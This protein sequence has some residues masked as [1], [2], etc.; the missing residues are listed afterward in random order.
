MVTADPN[1]TL[2]NLIKDQWEIF[3]DFSKGFIIA[4][5]GTIISDL[6]N[7]LRLQEGDLIDIYPHDNPTCNQEENKLIK[8]EDLKSDL[9]K[10]NNGNYVSKT[11]PANKNNW[12]FSRIIVGIIDLFFLAAAITT[13]LL[14]FLTSLSLSIAIPIVLTVLCVFIAILFFRWHKILPK[15]SPELWVKK[16]NGREVEGKNIDGQT[17]E[18]CPKSQLLKERNI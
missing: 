3:K 16:I 17:K 2:I 14:Y 9:N 1:T 15:I 18:N 6:N 7:E 5:R 11:D 10:N 12:L 13:F 4:F 8:I